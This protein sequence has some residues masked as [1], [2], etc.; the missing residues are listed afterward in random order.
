MSK[1]QFSEQDMTREQWLP[2]LACLSPVELRSCC[3][4]HH[5]QLRPGTSGPA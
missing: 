4:A 5:G 2:A 3:N 1:T